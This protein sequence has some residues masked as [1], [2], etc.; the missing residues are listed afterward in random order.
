[1]ALLSV[2]CRLQLFMAQRF[3]FVILFSCF[4]VPKHR[5]SYVASRQHAVIDEAS[6]S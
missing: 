2:C 1:M 5:E 6:C 3:H 4:Y